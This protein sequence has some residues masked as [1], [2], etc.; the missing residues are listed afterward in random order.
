MSRKHYSEDEVIRVL[1]RKNDIR[2][3]SFKKEIQILSNKIFTQR[4]DIIDNPA[5]KFD[6][7]NGSWGKIDYLV[8]VHNYHTCKVSKF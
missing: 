5:K 8:K 6:L 4:G 3:N 7:G 2:V 1:S